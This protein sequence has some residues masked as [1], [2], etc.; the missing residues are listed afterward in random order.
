V[1]AGSS[2][3]ALACEHELGDQRLT[4]DD[5][6]DPGDDR[7]LWVHLDRTRERAQR[8]LR[9]EAGLEPHV[10]DALL[11][12]ETR[13][14]FQA[15]GD[16]LLVILRGVN[17]NPGAEPDEFIAL[18]MWFDQTR[19]I[20]LRQHRFQTII[21]L[22]QQAQRQ[23]APSKPGAFLAAVAH[24]LATRMGASVQNLEDMLDEVEDAMIAE[25]GDGRE[26]RGTLSEIRRQ[27][28]S[29]RRFVVP[30]R[31][32]L[33]ELTLQQIGLL[34][35][36]DTT[37]LRFAAEQVA[38]V[39]DALEELRDRAAVNQEEIRARHEARIGRT[40]YLLTLIAAIAL[41][42]S[43]LTGLLGINVG[44]IPLADSA[45]GFVIICAIMVTIAVAEIVIL[46]RLR[47]L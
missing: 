21:E 3:V 37:L 30:Q 26:S 17:M 9:N 6:R 34:T 36:S 23:S 45:S 13:P 46:R 44:G 19:V 41:P 42:L 4:W 10:V 2:P 38:R 11:A 14:T 27:A 7:V 39:A 43:L 40:I 1:V 33:R 29:I 18:R 47:W 8:W 16:G 35:A 31:D 25:T 32:A 5:L 24:G 28:I 15:I 22:R 12:E 20:T